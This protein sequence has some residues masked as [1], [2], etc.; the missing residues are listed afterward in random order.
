MSKEIQPKEEKAAN[1]LPPTGEDEY[2]LI[3]PNSLEKIIKEFDPNEPEKNIIWTTDITT[4][5][6]ILVK[7][8]GPGKK[9]HRTLTYIFRL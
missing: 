8:K 6:P 3:S 5:L 4:E 9:Y 7:K 2:F 1:P